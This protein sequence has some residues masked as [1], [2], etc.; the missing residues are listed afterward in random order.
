MKWYMRH[1]QYEAHHMIKSQRWSAIVVA[2]GYNIVLPNVTS[3]LTLSI[4]LK[5][6]NASS[7][8]ILKFQKYI[9]LLNI[10]S[11]VLFFKMSILSSF[12]FFLINF[13]YFF[14]PFYFTSLYT[15]KLSSH[16]WFCSLISLHGKANL[17]PSNLP[18]TVTSKF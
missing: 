4:Y 7:V 12:F 16:L 15:M 10:Y 6:I 14:L 17:F 2:V 5:P 1:S 3:N 18:I 8:I 13:Y 9:L 11:Q